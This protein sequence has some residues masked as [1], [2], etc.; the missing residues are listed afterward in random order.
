M[1]MTIKE[2][3]TRKPLTA[4]EDG[5]DDHQSSREHPWMVYFSTFVSVCGSYEL[6]T[7]TGYSSPTQTAI[8]EDLNLSLEQYSLFGSILTIGAMIGAITSGLI[9]DYIGRKGAMRVYTAFCVAGWLV[10]YFARGALALYIG[11]LA[12]GYGMG[13]FSYVVPVF[14]AEIAPKNLRGLLTAANQCMISAGVSISYIIGNVLTWR[15]LALVDLAPCAFLLFGLFFI[16]ESPRWL[17]KTGHQKEFES[18]LQKLR[19][20]NVNISQEAAEIQRII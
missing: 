20:K 10:I 16:P 6:G 9:A 4:V 15:A 17:A 1:A 7:C 5:P 14:I 18:S 2:E 12:T 8:R 19:G 3:E 13:A 11:R